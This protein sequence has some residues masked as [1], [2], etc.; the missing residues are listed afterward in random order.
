MTQIKPICSLSLRKCQRIWNSSKDWPPLSWSCL[1]ESFQ[2]NLRKSRFLTA[3]MSGIK[4]DHR[5]IPKGFPMGVLIYEVRLS[6][7]SNVNNFWLQRN[8]SPWKLSLSST[9]FIP[10]IHWHPSPCC[11]SISAIIIQSGTNHLPGFPTIQHTIPSHEHL[12][13]ETGTVSEAENCSAKELNPPHQ[14]SGVSFGEIHILEV[15]IIN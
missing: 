9:W 10:S 2:W 8:F 14:T 1:I 5:Y 12:L 4:W 7:V 13:D 3:V 11:T 15:D 6:S